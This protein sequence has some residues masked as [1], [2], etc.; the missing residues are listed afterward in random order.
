ME[1]E[2]V[3]TNKT[4]DTKLCKHCQS[5]M[6][7][8]AK[9]CPTC[10]RKQGGAGKWIVIGIV[11]LLILGGMAGSGD[12][13]TGNKVGEVAQETTDKKGDTKQ[14]ASAENADVETESVE[15][16]EESG[17]S[18]KSADEKNEFVA[19]DVVETDSVKISYISAGEYTPESEYLAAKEGYVYY[20]LEFE[21]ENISDV[22]QLISSWSFEGYA[23]GYAIDEA[24][25]G[26]DDTLSATLSP[27][28]KAKGAIYYEVPVDATEVIA[29]YE[30]DFWTQG[31]I[32]FVIK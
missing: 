30:T 9:V 16:V 23:D 32:V 4:G 7:K 14:D 2:N 15:D 24:Y 21:V 31:K 8:K 22:D 3:T 17:D 12:G 20:R 6:P 5:E 18:V 25:A 13:D 1:N 10:R 28:K 27:G 26:A 29:E 11:V 19:G